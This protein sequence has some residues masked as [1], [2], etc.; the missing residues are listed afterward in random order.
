MPPPPL[1]VSNDPSIHL[2]YQVD[3]AVPYGCLKGGYK[4]TYRNLNKTRKVYEVTTPTSTL[5]VGTINVEREQRLNMLKNKIKSQQ[6][7]NTNSLSTPPKK[8]HPFL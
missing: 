7:T 6:V 3:S 2:N 1:K 8:K 4:P 5:N